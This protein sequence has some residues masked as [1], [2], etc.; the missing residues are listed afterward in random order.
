MSIDH[1]LK[2]FSVCLDNS[3]SLDNKFH[4]VINSARLEFIFLKGEACYVDEKLDDPCARSISM[5]AP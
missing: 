5:G 3:S 4:L 2:V 1:L